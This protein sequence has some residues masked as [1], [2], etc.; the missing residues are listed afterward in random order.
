MVTREQCQEGRDRL[1]QLDGFA[2]GSP[3]FGKSNHF[4][5]AD[6]RDT[7][8]LQNLPSSSGCRARYEVVGATS[9]FFEKEKHFVVREKML[10]QEAQ[11]EKLLCVMQCQWDRD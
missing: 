7:F 4:E 2:Q 9:S 3:W 8:E 5:T 6:S 11:E 10:L 1:C